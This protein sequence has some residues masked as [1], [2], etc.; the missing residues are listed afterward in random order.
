MFIVQIGEE[1]WPWMDVILVA[2]SQLTEIK[3]VKTLNQHIST[4]SYF[5][6]VQPQFLC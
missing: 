3:S 4:V 1:E 6:L 2:V 5:K